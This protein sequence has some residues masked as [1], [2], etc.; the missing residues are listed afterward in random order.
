MLGYAL[1][2]EPS[3]A[4]SLEECAE[5]AL[6]AEPRLSACL[7]ELVKAELVRKTE[8]GFRAG[9]AARSAPL[10][11]SLDEASVRLLHMRLAAISDRR[12][13]AM[14]S[15]QHLLRASHEVDGLR[16]LIAHAIE[17][18]A[19]T[20][21]DPSAFFTLLR[22]LPDG[23]LETYERCIAA[24]DRLNR[25]RSEKRALLI[26]LTGLLSNSNGEAVDMHRTQE[27]LDILAYE[28]G[29]DL[30]DTLPATIEPRARA[31]AVLARAEAR[32]QASPAA[33]TF[34]AAGTALQ[35]LVANVL[36]AIGMIAYTN[37]YA[38]WRQLPSLEAFC[39]LSAAVSL[40]H[41][42][43]QGVGLRIAGR[44]EEALLVYQDVLARVGAADRA[45]LGA[46]HAL[47]TR[48][49]VM[50]A[51]GT[52]QAMMGQAECLTW[53]AQIAEEPRFES[54][55]LVIRQL[56]ALFQGDG[57]AAR[58]IRRRVEALRLESSAS[59][60]SEAHLEFGELLARAL[61][62]DL[63]GIKRSSD[64]LASRAALHLPFRAASSYGRGEYHRICGDAVAALH[65]LD[66]ALALMKPGEDMLWAPAAA[67][68]VRA[69]TELGR[70]D[71]ACEA[72]A[73]Y[74][75]LGAFLGYM[76]N[77]LS[78]AWAD[79]LLARGEHADA[80]ALAEATI[81]R[82][83][84]AK[85]GGLTLSVAY[86]LRARVAA[87]SGED[88]TFQ[89][90]MALRA[91]NR[92]ARQRS[93]A[94]GLYGS[95]PAFLAD[96]LQ[97]EH[98]VLE[99]FRTT[100]DEFDSLWGRLNAGLEVIGLH[101]QARSGAL[102]IRTAGGLVRAGAYGSQHDEPQ[103]DAW[104]THFFKQEIAEYVTDA[105]DASESASGTTGT[106]LPYTP[107]LLGH[108]AAEGYVLT[109]LAVFVDSHAGQTSLVAKLALELSRNVAQLDNVV[110]ISFV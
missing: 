16:K 88:T 90:Y 105:A 45:G 36:S 89:K 1:A 65:E 86:E 11:A 99:H 14:R 41:A 49:R 85:I 33:E 69:L 18:T 81:E 80:T 107:V 71:D 44:S 62:N 27:L 5:V 7:G 10:A 39:P 31:V 50:G 72:A 3:F 53:A 98:E 94:A 77:Y 28:A 70:V 95:L 110:P 82:L 8:D 91:A 54:H 55:A 60:A 37:S 35:L 46:S 19:L 76:R 24:C 73:N 15:A 106:V 83:S 67:A 109:G 26:R 102:L 38:A 87:A 42:I 2:A 79:A 68:R 97:S 84:A 64:A 23:W 40:V 96:E 9:D 29:L 52:L 63:T 74:W 20:D 103:L 43:V 48:F 4:F 101:M 22:G 93:L 100:L 75:E 13:D 17:S 56:H 61:A 6:I 104:A 12:G 47:A 21:R 78:M 59:H 66:D 57:P 30:L 108:D 58:E 51:I 25:P 32:R 34:L 92:R